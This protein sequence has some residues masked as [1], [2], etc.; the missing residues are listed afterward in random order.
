MRWNTVH[1]IAW[2]TS[3]KACLY[4][5]RGYSELFEDAGKVSAER[6]DRP[7]AAACRNEVIVCVVL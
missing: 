5:M 1:D 2:P 7:R 4:P 6:A 3:K